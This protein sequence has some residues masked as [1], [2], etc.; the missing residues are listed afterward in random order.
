LRRTYRITRRELQPPVPRRK[1]GERGLRALANRAR[2]LGR[3]HAF[4]CAHHVPEKRRAR[5]GARDRG[6]EARRLVDEDAVLRAHEALVREMRHVRD[7]ALA[8]I[9]I[10]QEHFAPRIAARLRRETALEARR[11]RASSSMATSVY[12]VTSR[13]S[14]ST[15]E[16]T[17]YAPMGAAW[18]RSS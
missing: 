10:A 3:C 18:R 7:R 15:C 1:R 5:R 16:L 11:P 2:V 13:A 4:A 12:R 8:R 17:R 6:R 9:D 14:R